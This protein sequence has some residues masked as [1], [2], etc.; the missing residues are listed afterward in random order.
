VAGRR[1]DPMNTLSMTS[2]VAFLFILGFSVY[3]FIKYGV[4][5]LSVIFFIFSLG[6]FGAMIDLAVIEGKTFPPKVWIITIV[7]FLFCVAMIFFLQRMPEKENDR[8]K[9]GV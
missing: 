8:K 1:S 7:I 4:K 3:Q 6:I 9:G 2:I 5:G